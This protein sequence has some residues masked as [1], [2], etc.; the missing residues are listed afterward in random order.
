MLPYLVVSVV[1]AR[2][3]IF[4]QGLQVLE[5]DQRQLLVVGDLEGD[6]EHAFLRLAQIHQPR[7]QQRPELRDRRADRMALLAEQ[8]PEDHGIGLEVL[9]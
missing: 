4:E 1:G 3:Q 8:I 5:I 7:Q 9:V 6:V 2:R